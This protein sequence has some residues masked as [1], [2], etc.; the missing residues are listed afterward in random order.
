MVT[1]PA[2]PDGLPIL[3]VASDASSSGRLSV[4]GTIRPISP[5]DVE[6]IRDDLAAWQGDLVGWLDSVE[7]GGRGSAVDR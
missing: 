3:D 6:A 2:S 7:R 4:A 1:A 5:A